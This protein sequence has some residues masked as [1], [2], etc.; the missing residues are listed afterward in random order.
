M[1][2]ST[3]TGSRVAIRTGWTGGNATTGTNAGTRALAKNGCKRTLPRDG[4]D[5]L[6]LVC[7]QLNALT[8]LWKYIALSFIV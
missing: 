5:G 8:L 4:V 1:G 7:C 3:P 6:S 2:L